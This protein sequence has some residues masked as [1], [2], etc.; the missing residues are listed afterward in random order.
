MRKRFW[1]SAVKVHMNLVPRLR[2]AIVGALLSGCL[3]WSSPASA[4]SIKLTEANSGASV[5]VTDQQFFWDSNWLPGAVQYAG[6]LGNVVF[7]LTLAL[8]DPLIG[9]PDNALLTLTQLSVTA[10]K[11]A[12]LTVEVID[13]DRTLASAPD[14]GIFL[15]QCR[16]RDHRRRQPRG[17]ILRHPEQWPSLLS[18]RL[19][20]AFRDFL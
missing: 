14:N 5:T 9:G 2:L 11:A 20:P 12:N 7:D 6:T 17:G 3:L 13:T 8:A 16:R 10:T 4:L 18:L 15:E 1:L 19:W